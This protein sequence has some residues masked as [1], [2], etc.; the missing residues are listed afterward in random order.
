M[1]FEKVVLFSDVVNFLSMI[2][3]DLK[4]PLEIWRGSPKDL[5]AFVVE[6]DVLYVAV[7]KEAPPEMLSFMRGHAED[8]NFVTIHARPGSGH[9][10]EDAAKE[11]GMIKFVCSE[12]LC[13]YAHETARSRLE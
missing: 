10:S 4:I 3:E 7:F 9:T 6:P 1:K 11:F 5:K 12:K 2:L 13:A 8:E